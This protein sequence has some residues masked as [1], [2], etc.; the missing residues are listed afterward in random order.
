VNTCHTGPATLT[1]SSN[2]LTVFVDFVLG[3]H[4]QTVPITLPVSESFH[5]WFPAGYGAWSVDDL[6]NGAAG[7]GPGDAFEFVPCQ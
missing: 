7:F 3:N 4:V 5:Y 1:V 6:R 2:R